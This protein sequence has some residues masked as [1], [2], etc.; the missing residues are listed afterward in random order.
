VQT[1]DKKFNTRSHANRFRARRFR[2][3]FITDIFCF[4]YLVIITINGIGPPEISPED[5]PPR[6]NLKNG[7]NPPTRWDV[8]LS[9]PLDGDFFEN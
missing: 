7:T 5:Y 3:I 8:T 6:E 9:D 4:I 2:A 1:A